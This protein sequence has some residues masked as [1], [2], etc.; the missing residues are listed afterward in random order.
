MHTTFEIIISSTIAFI[1]KLSF[2][3]LS[4]HCHLLERER[5]KSGKEGQ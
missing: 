1:K 5:A 2:H 3:E 4:S